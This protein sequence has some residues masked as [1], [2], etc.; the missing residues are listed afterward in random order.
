MIRDMAEADR[1]QKHEEEMRE[2]DREVRFRLWRRRFHAAIA[3]AGAVL[4][5]A[6][7]ALLAWCCMSD[8]AH[9]FNIFR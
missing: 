7:L 5:V 3:L 9:V 1:Q 4:A 2:Y 6:T 8:A